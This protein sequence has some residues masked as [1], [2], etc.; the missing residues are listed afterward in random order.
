VLS[1]EVCTPGECSVYTQ[2]VSD[3]ECDAT[4]DVGGDSAEDRGAF[5]AG[6]CCH[7]VYLQVLGSHPIKVPMSTPTKNYVIAFSFC[8]EV[9][10]RERT[11]LGVLDGRNLLLCSTGAGDTEIILQQV[12]PASWVYLI[13]GPRNKA[14]CP[15]YIYKSDSNTSSMAASFAHPLCR[16]RVIHVSPR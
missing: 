16:A 7:F 1:R 4:D 6:R 9:H 13:R 2:A 11:C 10:S 14:C 12:L 15:Q 8:E 3:L 5:Q